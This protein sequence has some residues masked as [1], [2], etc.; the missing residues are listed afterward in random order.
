MYCSVQQE[1]EIDTRKL[2]AIMR[3]YHPLLYSFLFS[4]ASWPS[5]DPHY[6][7]IVP[8]WSLPQYTIMGYIAAQV[9]LTQLP[10]LV[11]SSVKIW[12]VF[13]ATK[14]VVIRCKS[15]D[16]HFYLHTLMDGNRVAPFFSVRFTSIRVSLRLHNLFPFI[17]TH[18]TPR[19]LHLVGIDRN[20]IDKNVFLAFGDINLVVSYL[21][22]GDA[23]LV[24]PTS[25][26][27]C[28]Q[29]IAYNISIARQYDSVAHRAT[30]LMC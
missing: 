26:A 8:N 3:C 15:V 5:A 6:H 9:C 20:V 23:M 1:I 17:Q 30:L 22:R 13:L 7:S 25:L 14:T 28:Q 12:A 24:V 10:T 27:P 18:T 29:R 16:R 11:A 21:R 2:L 4:A 19:W